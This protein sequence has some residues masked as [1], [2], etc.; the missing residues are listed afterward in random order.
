MSG[1]VTAEAELFVDKT[2][3]CPGNMKCREVEEAVIEEKH[4]KLGRRWDCLHDDSNMMIER[5]LGTR[6][7]Q[8]EERSQF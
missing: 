6:L 1:F 8:R 2:V 5:E 3:L 7:Q 4:K